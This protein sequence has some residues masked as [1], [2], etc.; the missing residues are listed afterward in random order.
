MKVKYTLKYDGKEIVRKDDTATENDGCG[1]K[2]TY[3]LSLTGIDAYI[4]DVQK[5]IMDKKGTDASNRYIYPL[6]R[7]INTS[8][9]SCEFLKR[10]FEV[11]P[12]R[13]SRILMKSGS[14]DDIIK[15]IKRVIKFN[16]Y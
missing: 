13:I 11:S 2:K 8:R 1:M 6:K 7:Y 16:N 12:L 9:A 3:T 15:D 10:L 14:D 5:Y 4:W